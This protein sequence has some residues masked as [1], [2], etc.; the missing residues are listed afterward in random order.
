MLGVHCLLKVSTTF[1]VQGEGLGGQTLE[2]RVRKRKKKMFYGPD[3]PR[4][5]VG[6]EYMPTEDHFCFVV[7]YI[8]FCSSSGPTYQHAGVIQL[9]MLSKR[10]LVGY[11]YCAS[12]KITCFVFLGFPG[13]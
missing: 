5:E 9:H 12:D 11:I 10:T 7:F 6:G 3:R 1:F 13:K 4:W 8:I 2:F